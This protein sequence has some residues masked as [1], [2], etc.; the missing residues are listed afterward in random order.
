[1]LQGVPLGLCL[2]S[3]PFLLQMSVSY[4]ALGYFS[5]CSWPYSL[6][7]LWSP[8]V[9]SCYSDKLG[10]RK[11]WIVPIQLIIG[12]I[13]IGL[14]YQSAGTKRGAWQNERLFVVWLFSRLHAVRA[15]L[16]IRFALLFPLFAV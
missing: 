9:D 12:A 6:K 16:L 8:I 11:S 7:L 10:R 5:F 13:M 3:V 1:M 15:D 14:S 4:T 2:G